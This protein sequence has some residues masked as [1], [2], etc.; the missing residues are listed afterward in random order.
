[1]YTP[2]RF[3]GLGDELQ[4][5]D[6]SAECSRHCSRIRLHEDYT[7]N[8][9]VDSRQLP[10]EP[11]STVRNSNSAQHVPSTLRH[12]RLRSCRGRNC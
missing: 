8:A 1:M 6:Y 4:S 7:V 5:Q 2:S 11:V 3:T 12:G 9:E 10:H